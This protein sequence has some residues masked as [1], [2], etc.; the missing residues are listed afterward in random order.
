[1]K[2][3]WVKGARL[4]G[5]AQAVGEELAKL[6]AAN[7]DKLKPQD[8]V[9]AAQPETSLLHPCFEWDDSKAAGL[10]RETQAR[11]L[12]RCIRVVQQAHA[13]AEPEP[14]RAYV[15]IQEGEDSSYRPI[16]SVMSDSELRQRAVSDAIEYVSRAKNKLEQ[17]EELAALYVAVEK[18][19]TELVEFSM[20][21]RKQE[22][23]HATMSIV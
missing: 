16:A 23:R 3:Q 18:V 5:D 12:I 2:Y 13:D 8:I 14:I 11:S 19:E 22:R 4:A 17:F 9:Q 20:K 6:A 21:A 1:M 7:D 15:H 10:H